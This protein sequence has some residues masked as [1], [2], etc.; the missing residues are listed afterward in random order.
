M[1]HGIYDSILISWEK[2]ENPNADLRRPYRVNK[3]KVFNGILIFN[4]LLTKLLATAGVTN[5]EIS[6]AAPSIVNILM[7]TRVCRCK[8]YDAKMGIYSAKCMKYTETQKYSNI[9]DYSN[10]L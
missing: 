4:T 8:R 2:A 5:P 6:F 10:R 1:Y 9:N 3:L 7:F